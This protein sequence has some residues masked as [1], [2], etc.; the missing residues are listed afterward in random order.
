MG[1][2]WPKRLNYSRQVANKDKMAIFTKW[3]NMFS[4]L[5]FSPTGHAPAPQVPWLHGTVLG[6]HAMGDAAAVVRVMH[7]PGGLA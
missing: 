2:T 4:S 1:A 3:S 5:W 7:M 6:G